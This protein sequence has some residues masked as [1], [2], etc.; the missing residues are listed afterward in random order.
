MAR[1]YTKRT[2]RPNAHR[3]HD[4]ATPKRYNVE[5][6]TFQNG[7]FVFSTDLEKWMFGKSRR[8]AKYPN[9]F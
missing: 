3:H 7:E 8:G 5:G 6:F 1:K 9:L 4:V 2:K